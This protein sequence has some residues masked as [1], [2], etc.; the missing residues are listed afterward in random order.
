MANLELLEKIVRGILT[1]LI[2]IPTLSRYT[3]AVEADPLGP[4]YGLVLEGR[5]S[6]FFRLD[7]P[8]SCF[9]MLS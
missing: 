6:R 9:A 2:F 7:Y 3:F 4:Q 1:G 8:F 5:Q